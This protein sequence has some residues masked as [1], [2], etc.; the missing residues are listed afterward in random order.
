[1]A[2]PDWADQNA[3]IATGTCG[4]ISRAGALYH[5]NSSAFKAAL[6]AQRFSDKSK[7]DDKLFDLAYSMI[8]PAIPA[9]GSMNQEGWQKIL[10][11][12]IGADIVKDRA[13]PPSAKEGILWTNKYAAK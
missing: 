8:S 5:S 3:A 1:M 4:A 12:S 7:L 13:K 10:D 11:F 6:C 9:W 2:R